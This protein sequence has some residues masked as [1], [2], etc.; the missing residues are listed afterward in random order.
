MKLR[1][2]CDCNIMLSEYFVCTASDRDPD[3]CGVT[4]ECDS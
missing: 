1:R 2:V 4:V 3:S